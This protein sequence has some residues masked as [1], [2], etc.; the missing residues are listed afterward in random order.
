M[1]NGF[2]KETAPLNDE[3][4]SLLAGFVRGLLGHVGKNNAITNK[5]I[6][7]NYKRLEIDV[8]DARVRKLINHVRTHNLVPC[9]VASSV[10]Y[11][12][13]NDAVEIGKYIQSLD[14][15]ISAIQAMKDSVIKQAKKTNQFILNFNQ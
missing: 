10:G 6:Q 11:Y 15:R 13:S 3:E 5:E 4:K 2:D 14:Q 9:L 8:S 1:I 12:V 7:A